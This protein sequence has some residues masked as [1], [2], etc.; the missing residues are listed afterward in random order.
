MPQL[1]HAKAKDC[2]Y[3]LQITVTTILRGKEI[4]VKKCNSTVHKDSAGVMMLPGIKFMTSSKT[5]IKTKL[6][7][8]EQTRVA[9]N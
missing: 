2:Y 5:K 7:K 8:T 4:M 3:G 1:Q 9:W 6:A